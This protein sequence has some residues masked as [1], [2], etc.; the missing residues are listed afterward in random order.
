M[1]LQSAISAATFVLF[2]SALTD[3][4]LQAAIV[5]DNGVFP[6]FAGHITKQVDI[7]KEA[8]AYASACLSWFYKGSKKA[9]PSAQ[10]IAWRLPV[11]LLEPE[12]DCPREYPG[13]METARD[14]FAKKQ[15]LLS[16]SLTV[17]EFALVAD[18]NDDSQ[19][20]SAE[21]RDL[22]HSLSLAYDAAAPPRAA[23]ATLT[24]RFDQWYRT[25]N[26]EEVMQGMSTLYERGYRMTTHDRAELDR[27]MK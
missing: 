23:G 3:R 5:V 26:L 19:Y 6:T 22:F 27:V 16:V 8:F 2:L 11:R 25:R 7:D 13:G 14:D 10:G 17:Y 1:P 21:L 12:R 15:A 20:N 4:E 18:H 24:A 9:P